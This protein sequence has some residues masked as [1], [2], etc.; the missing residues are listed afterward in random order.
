MFWKVIFGIELITSRQW[1]RKKLLIGIDYIYLVENLKN[2]VLKAK[3]KK[4]YTIEEYL[5]LEKYSEVK[6]EFLNG[7]VIEMSGV[8]FNHNILSTNLINLLKTLVKK[9][10]EKFYVLGS[11]MKIQIE[12]FNHFRYPD[13][14]VICEKPKFFN[15]R[16]DVIVNPLLILE[17]LSVTTQEFDRT[18]K[19]E[20]YKTIPTFQEYVLVN[21]DRPYLT[22]YFRKAEKQ[23]LIETTEGMD[24]FAHLKSID[25]QL[26][27]NDVY[28]D[29]ELEA[30]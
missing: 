8:S 9:K 12:A 10:K 25:I 23:W 5:E 19:F 28:E 3:P 29:I 15:D 26:S 21:Q 24:N 1:N 13:L 2:M 6:H 22:S 30:K 20:L 14:V 16:K 11:D 18:G 4:Y 17:I 27:L 7:K